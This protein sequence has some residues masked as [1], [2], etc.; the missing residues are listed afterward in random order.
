[1]TLLA[2]EESAGAIKDVGGCPG[3]SGCPAVEGDWN[4][5]FSTDSAPL[6]GVG[7]VFAPE[8]LL[9]T[10]AAI[11]PAAVVIPHF[12]G[13][14]AD[15]LA[16]TKENQAQVP[17]VEV[18]SNHT[19]PPD[20]AMGWAS[21]TINTDVRLGFIG[22]SDDHS[23]HP[24]RSMWGTRYGYIAA[25]AASLD[26]PAILDAIR[27]RHT[28]ACSHADRPIVKVSANRGAMMGDSV[29]LS[30]D[31]DPAM[32]VSVLSRAQVTAVSVVRDG[33]TV[34]QSTP[35]SS[36]KSAPYAISASYGEPLPASPT[37]YH[38]K[39]AFDNSA[40]VWTSPIWF[41]R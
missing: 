24:G 30:A 15:L 13:R 27:R 11:D 12:G 7:S 36:T 16:L 5:Y 23:G 1:V 38:W 17:V 19:G 26:R 25:W 35:G 29:V 32:T 37:S 20:G 33:A 40:V 22:S 2:F 3:G 21:Q 41:A 8:G 28:Y 4:V 18:I 6:L 39:I 9:A 10:V 34:W 31:E 14:R